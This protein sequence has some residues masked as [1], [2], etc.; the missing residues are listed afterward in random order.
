M[1]TISK[2]NVYSSLNIMSNIY[3]GKEMVNKGT[4]G[5]PI[6]PRVCEVYN[7]DSLEYFKSVT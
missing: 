6:G 4:E 2:I 5:Q 1:P 7:L 3:L